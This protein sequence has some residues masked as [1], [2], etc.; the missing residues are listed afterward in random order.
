MYV[1]VESEYGASKQECL[2]DIHEDTTSDVLFIDCL[3]RSECNAAHDEQHC[4]EQ[5]DCQF[6][7]HITN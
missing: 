4:A 3:V 5:F 1:V 2:G 7:F 6:S